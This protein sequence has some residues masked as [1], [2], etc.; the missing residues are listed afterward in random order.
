MVASGMKQN[1]KDFLDSSV[2]SMYL[3]YGL[4]GLGSILYDKGY[5]EVKMF[6]GDNKSIEGFFCEIECTNVDIKA[7]SYPVFVSIPSFFAVSWALEF[8]ETL[9]LKKPSVKVIL[10]GRWVLDQNLDWC[11]NTFKLV[12]FFSIGCPDENVDKLLFSEN[13]AQFQPSQNCLKPFSRFHFN[14]L[15]QFKYYQPVIEL[16]RGCGRGCEFCLERHYPVS[17]IKSAKDVIYEAKETC[18]VYGT[19]ELNFYFEASIFN[20]TLEWANEFLQFYQ[21]ENMKFQWRFETRV[22]TIDPESLKILSQAGL[23]VIDLGLESASVVQLKKMGKSKNPTE[24]LSKADSLLQK[25]Y[26]YG[27]WSKINILLYMGET[28]LTLMETMAWLDARN[29]YIK[30]VSV[31]PLIVYLNGDQTDDF[32]LHIEKET[33][34]GVEKEKL[35]ECGYLF[36]SLSKEMSI[37]KSQ[38]ITNMLAGRYM[39]QE[40]YVQLKNVCYSRRNL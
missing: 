7:L 1:K 8:I 37:K 4:L 34:V 19:D 15:N 23:K 35:Y 40:D 22:D 39:S 14:I 20:P 27:I 10:G 24:Y 12:D 13:W 28:D 29:K 16:C 3:N 18:S 33:S 6:Q 38:R 26:E 9:K 36:I 2:E 31:N 30:G 5:T 25:M 21:Q 17:Q 32:V 11:R